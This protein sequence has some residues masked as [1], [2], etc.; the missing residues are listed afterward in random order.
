VEAR[1]RLRA[2]ANRWA[3]GGRGNHWGDYTGFDARGDGVGDVP[4]RRA[5]LLEDL[6]G[7]APALRAFLFTPAHLALE[8][9]ARLVPLAEREAIVMDPAPLMR[10][11]VERAGADLSVEENA[12]GRSGGPAGP[13]LTW[14]G[15]AM[16]LPAA[17]VVYALRSSGRRP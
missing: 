9:A 5:D 6:A 15:L 8:T 2:D 7:R 12:A 16:L 14:V 13:G 4:Y 1:G 17:S 11:P 10:P 3:S